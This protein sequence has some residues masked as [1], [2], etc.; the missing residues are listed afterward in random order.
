VTISDRNQKGIG[1][2]GSEYNANPA[3]GIAAN[4]AENQVWFTEINPGNEVTGI[5]VYDLPQGVELARVELHDSA[6]SG[7]TTVDLK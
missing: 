6:F 3:A 1:T 4:G 2:N 7:G 5:V